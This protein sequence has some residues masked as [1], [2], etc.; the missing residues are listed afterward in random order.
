MAISFSSPSP[1]KLSVERRWKAGYAKMIKCQ[2]M[3]MIMAGPMDTK[4]HEGTY[5]GFLTLLKWG[6]VGS[7]ILGLIVFWL[8]A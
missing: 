7:I 3:R 1:S 8:A 5:D 6:S 2:R 4:Q